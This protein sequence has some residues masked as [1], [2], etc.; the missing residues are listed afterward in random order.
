MKRLL[1]VNKRSRELEKVTFKGQNAYFKKSSVPNRPLIVRL[2]NWS[3][4]YSS[5]DPISFEA[6]KYDVNYIHPNFQGPNNN[7][8]ACGSDKVIKDIDN[9]IDFAVEQGH[10]DIDKIFILGVSG[11]GHA[12]LMH[13]LKSSYKVNTYMAWV[14]VTDLEDWY[15]ES[16]GRKNH[17][18][19][20]ILACTN[21]NGELNLNEAYK[22]SPMYQ[23]IPK[24]KL[25]HTKLKLYTG[26]H[27]GYTGEVPIT[28][29]LKFY[30]K[31]ADGFNE[32]I[33]SNDDILY[34]LEKRKGKKVKGYIG[35]R[36]VHFYQTFRNVEITVFE[37]GHGVLSGYA[38]KELLRSKEHNS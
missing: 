34:L 36:E 37:G 8:N 12:A 16:L 11:G 20:E 18:Y 7:P 28:H 15:Y 21:S 13:F 33:I 29:A 14:P 23:P 1:G 19:K 4:D 22:R 32:E 25:T 9:A 31:L 2:H 6:V 5:Y 35:D 30:N 26:I 17:Y 24:E 27:D 3:S 10:V 38:V